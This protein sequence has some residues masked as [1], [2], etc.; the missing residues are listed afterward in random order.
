MSRNS[1]RWSIVLIVFSL[2]VGAC[3][4]G[5][6]A[7]A[8]TEATGTTQATETTA[9]ADLP[10][11]GLSMAFVYDGGIVG[12]WGQGHDR[13]RKYVVENLPGV[14]TVNIEDI[15]PGL[16]AQNAMEDLATEGYDMVVMVSF[17]QPD[18][19][20]VA[21]NFPDTKFLHWGGWENTSNSASY[22]AA[23]E[24]G[25]FLDGMIAG[26]MTKSNIIG[27][28][29]GFPLEGIVREVDGFALGVQAVN[30]DAKV[31]AVFT[32]SW[33]DPPKEQQAAEAFL[34]A[35]ADVLVSAL[36]SPATAQVAVANDVWY[37]GYGEDE[38]ALAPDNWLTALTYQWGPYYLSQAK[39]VIE[40]TFKPHL[41]YGTIADGAVGMATLH[42]DIPQEV[43][44]MVMERRQQLID[45]T[46]DVLAGPVVDNK[47]NVV[48]AEGDTVPH[49]E[50]ISCCTWLNQN[51][52]GELAEG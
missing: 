36:N 35:G 46:F 12:G 34:A 30:P 41:F 10:G 11:E 52:E 22:D 51:V 15:L 38:S 39:A 47:G 23:A 20:A 6:D 48:I 27:Y 17:F 16:P 45:G 24:E 32:N 43:L 25:R 7:T 4:G 3:G 40:G 26:S 13:A 37:V 9:A 31:I 49:D 21:E 42:P 44:D 8:T 5:G 28:T 2:L 18:I 1:R 50:R 29:M 33:F 19:L 14:E